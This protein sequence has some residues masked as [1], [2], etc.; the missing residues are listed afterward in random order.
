MSSLLTIAESIWNMVV[1]HTS[2]GYSASTTLTY[3]RGWSTKMPFSYFQDFPR[4]SHFSSTVLHQVF[5]V[6]DHS[7]FTFGKWDL[8][9]IGLS[10]FLNVWHPPPLS[11]FDYIVKG[12]L[13]C[14]PTQFWPVYSD[15]TSQTSVHNSLKPLSNSRDHNFVDELRVRSKQWEFHS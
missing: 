15:F 12:L 2:V 6:G 10:P 11:P 7:S 9:A 5:L 8:P 1:I 4:C 13:A 14:A 3:R